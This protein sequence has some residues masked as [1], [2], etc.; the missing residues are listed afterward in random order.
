MDTLFLVYL[1][2]AVTETNGLCGTE[3]PAHLAA[4]AHAIDEIDLAPFSTFCRC[5]LRF[6]DSTSKIQKQWRCDCC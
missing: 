4:Y 5:S 2:P 1:V 3:H 6:R